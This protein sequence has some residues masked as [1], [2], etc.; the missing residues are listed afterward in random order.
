MPKRRQRIPISEFGARR[1]QP[2]DGLDEKKY[3]YHWFADSPGRIEAAKAAGYTPFRSTE[4]TA[5][6]D[7]GSE[8]SIVS[9]KAT[10]QRS[11]FMQI[12][13]ELYQEDQQALEQRNR[14]VDE[15]ISRQEFDG[16]SVDKVYTPDGGGIKSVIKHTAE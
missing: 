7:V 1:L 4:K 6:S 16:K 11:V 13:I 12:P 9:D 10:G 2:P 8:H 15:A 3:H 5:Q 14:E